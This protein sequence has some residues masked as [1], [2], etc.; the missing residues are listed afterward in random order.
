MTETATTLLR[1]IML[2]LR[3]KVT[4]I[5]IIYISR[6]LP[7]FA[8]TISS[9]TVAL[10]NEPWLGRKGLNAILDTHTSFKKKKF[11]DKT[12]APPSE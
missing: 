7:R 6:L 5:Y 2:K 9:G 10:R 3:R 1:N 12:D 11:D 8:E 4:P